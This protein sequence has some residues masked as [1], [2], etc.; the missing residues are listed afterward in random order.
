[1]RHYLMAAAACR[2]AD[3]MWIAP[4][5]LV[6]DR[7]GSASLAGLTAAAAQLA[8]LLSAPPLGAWLD[9]P[10]RRRAALAANQVILAG[11]LLAMLAASGP[12]MAV[13]AAL[14]G[15]TPPLVTG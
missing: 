6:L 11:A 5:L 2:L 12:W 8:T 13:C 7:T 4:V 10:G 14:A 3:A 1:M 9:R 15:V